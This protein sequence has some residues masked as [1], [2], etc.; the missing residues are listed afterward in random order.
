M[1][2]HMLGYKNP[3]ARMGT[4]L[5]RL[6]TKKLIDWFDILYI[7][8]DGDKAGIESAKRIAHDLGTVMKTIIPQMPK[9][10]DIDSLKPAKAE[11]VLGT[12]ITS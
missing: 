1:F 5:S 8:P 11:G 2:T 12:A 6:Q 10:F 9:G 4:H 3:V 7:V